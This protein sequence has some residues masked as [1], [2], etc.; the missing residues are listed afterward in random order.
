MLAGIVFQRKY[1]A[2]PACFGKNRAKLPPT[3]V[4][5]PEKK[6]AKAP[7]AEESDDD[8]TGD[9]AGHTPADDIILTE[10]ERILADYVKR[11]ETN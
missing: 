1:T 2:R 10:C 5:P 8:L 6:P 11:S 4:P 3:A 7:N 9:F